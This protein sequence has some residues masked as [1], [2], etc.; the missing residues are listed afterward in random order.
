MSIRVSK[1]ASAAG[2][3]HAIGS[4]RT[5]RLRSSDP[6]APSMRMQPPGP[7][8]LAGPNAVVPPGSRIPLHPLLGSLEMLEAGLVG[9][10]VKEGLHRVLAVLGRTEVQRLPELR[11]EVVRGALPVHVARAFHRELRVAQ[12]RLVLLEQR[13][14]EGAGA[15]PKLRA[16]HRLVDE[17]QL[18]RLLAVEAFAR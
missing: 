14:S 2:P 5:P 16:R 9:L 6:V 13:A 7:A 15:F 10:L 1:C 4:R 8:A 3:L 12:H 17:A 11:V 18:H